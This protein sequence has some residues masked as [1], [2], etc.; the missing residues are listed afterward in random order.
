MREVRAA[1]GILI[2][3]GVL[4]ALA[5]KVIEY[6]TRLT[7]L[8]EGFGAWRIVYAEERVYGFGPGGNDTGLVVYAMPEAMRESL[9]RQGIGWL[10][11]LAASGDR[12]RHRGFT[13]WHRTP[14]GPGPSWADPDRC[15]RGSAP[16]GT[17]PGIAV[18]LNRYGFGLP[19]RASVE[20]M[21]NQ[22]LFAPGAYWSEG[23]GALVVVIPETSRIVIAYAG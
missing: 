23:R 17:C 9:A 10:Q 2:L 7:Y 20:R 3:V 19:I 8:P 22:A 21:A 18:F 14:T 6:R 4:A 13:A 1:L 12:G 11:A 5:F 15:T 16:T